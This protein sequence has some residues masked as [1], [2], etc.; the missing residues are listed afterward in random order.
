MLHICFKVQYLFKC[1][2]GSLL[3]QPILQTFHTQRVCTKDVTYIH[4][5]LGYLWTILYAILK[6]IPQVGS[7]MQKINLW[8]IT[9]Q[10]PSQILGPV[11]NRKSRFGTDFYQLLVVE[12]LKYLQITWQNTAT[13]ATPFYFS[14]YWFT[15][16]INF[17][18]FQVIFGTINFAI[19]A[20]QWSHNL[21]KIL[22]I[23]FTFLS[24]KLK[25]TKTE[26]LTVSNILDW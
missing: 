19:V 11:P 1:E 9:C 20:F 13:S 6:I 12:I 18:W 21:D 25:I 14:P 4:Y 5:C 3:L 17:L 24:L 26:N 7:S 2:L 16:F 22:E 8:D 10:Y 15:I 23:Y